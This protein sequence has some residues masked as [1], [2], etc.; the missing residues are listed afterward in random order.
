MI[1]LRRRQPCRVCQ[2]TVFQ[3]PSTSGPYYDPV[4][5]S[6]GDENYRCFDQAIVCEDWTSPKDARNHNGKIDESSCRLAEDTVD[7]VKKNYSLITPVSEYTSFF[8]S[9]KPDGTVFVTSIAGPTR[10]TDAY[11][12]LSVDVSD[13]SLDEGSESDAKALTYPALH[14]FDEGENY[15]TAIDVQES[16]VAAVSRLTLSEQV[17]TLSPAPGTSSPEEPLQHSFNYDDASINRFEGEDSLE[18][19]RF[20]L[21]SSCVVETRDYDPSTATRN[22]QGR[23]ERFVRQAVPAFR[24]RAFTDAFSDNGDFSSLCAPNYDSAMKRLGDR[25]AGSLSNSA[26]SE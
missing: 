16:P 10:S 23:R 9:L 6:V 12:G 25:L 8:E 17:T 18:S 21:L 4:D 2:D 20:D 3:L 14:L 26:E 24:L 15:L 13:D 7:D 5:G 1:G 22:Q 11:T 19:D